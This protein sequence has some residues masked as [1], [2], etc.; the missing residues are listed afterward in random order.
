[1][2]ENERELYIKARKKDDY[3]KEFCEKEY[4]ALKRKGRDDVIKFILAK[5]IR[6]E[7]DS[8]YTNFGITSKI[9][10]KNKEI[11]ALIDKKNDIIEFTKN[12][13]IA[14][15]LP[16][17]YDDT[18]DSLNQLYNMLSAKKRCCLDI[19]RF[20]KFD[21]KLYAELLSEHKKNSV[22]YEQY[23]EKLSKANK[24]RIKTEKMKKNFDVE[25]TNTKNEINNKDIDD[26]LM[27]NVILNY[28]NIA[29]KEY[30][31]SYQRNKNKAKDSWITNIK[32]QIS[33]VTNPS[34]LKGKDS[35]LINNVF[36]FYQSKDNIDSLDKINNEIRVLDN[37]CSELTFNMN[38][39]NKLNFINVI[40]AIR[41]IFNEKEKLENEVYDL[42]LRKDYLINVKHRDY[43][44]EKKL[45]N[46]FEPVLDEIYREINGRLVETNYG[47]NNIYHE[48]PNTQS[49]KNCSNNKGMMHK[50]CC[51]IS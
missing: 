10:E 22:V 16:M 9:N 5:P 33:L 28:I 24:N 32:D 4:D 20:N 51:V 14:N 35:Q 6:K 2:P 47:Y 11:N 25:I 31:L 38:D 13:I 43:L 29:E 48:G 41:D 7:A 46:K 17:V 39:K 50:N 1:M 34:N 37:R 18:L 3:E 40:E 23:E 30:E 21:K 36:S 27:K 42:R 8:R 15:N 12:E 26:P 19:E 49:K 45:E 44:R